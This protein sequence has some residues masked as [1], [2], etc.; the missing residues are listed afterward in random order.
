MARRASFTAVGVAMMIAGLAL[1]GLSFAG[2]G[3][4]AGA[5]AANPVSTKLP[6]GA[7]SYWTDARI[8]G[9]KELTLL[10]TAD[11]DTASYGTSNLDFTRARVAPRAAVTSKP[12]RAA[13]KLFFTIPGS[14][15]FQCSASVI[16]L[17]LIVTAA[18]CLFDPVANTFFTNVIFIP[19]YDGTLSNA[20]PDGD[21]VTLQRPFGTWNATYLIVSSTWDTT[22]GALPNAGDFGILKVADKSFSGG[23]LTKVRTKVGYNLVPVTGHL[24]D[25]HVSMLGY[26]CNLDN[27]NIMQ[28]NDSSDHVVGG[29]NAWEYGADMTGGSSGGPWVENLGD[30][31]SQPPQGG[32][33]TRNA[34]VAVTS[35]GYND[36]NV[37]IL[38]ASG[39]NAEFTGI[40]N[41]ACA[42][43]AGN[44]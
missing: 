13:G 38:G 36:P 26:P 17:R 42:Q 23:P 11:P 22:N 27:C 35:Y 24:V 2:D 37:L 30:P 9:A 6:G 18:H 29:T 41:T 33:A 4:T 25:T 12:Y 32:F 40:L 3:G 8:K 31:L 39:F 16:K 14:G 10:R 43:Q 1:A 7:D 44:C 21:G 20:D 15:N 5:G 19:A 28:R 34:V